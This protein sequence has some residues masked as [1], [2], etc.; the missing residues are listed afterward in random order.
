MPKHRHKGMSWWGNDA[1]QSIT[2][3][4]GSQN[5]YNLHYSGGNN[6]GDRPAFQTYESGGGK[7]HN[8]A[9]P[10]TAVAVWKRTA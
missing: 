8:H 6:T 9:I 2:L 10:T 4:N 5:G 7:G 3:N 1:N